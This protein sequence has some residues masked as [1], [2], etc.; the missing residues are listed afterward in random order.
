MICSRFHGIFLIAIAVCVGLL[1]GTPSA[2]SEAKTKLG[3][4]AWAICGTKFSKTRP[5]GS[6]STCPPGRPP[7]NRD[8]ATDACR[9]Q[10]HVF[11]HI[12][13][14]MDDAWLC[15]YFSDFYR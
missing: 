10:M 1:A 6:M 11:G 14:K 13:M 5:P 4:K 2:V 3:G 15:N 7:M 9:D 8:E 12:V